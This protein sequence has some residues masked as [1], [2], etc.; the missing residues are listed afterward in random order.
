MNKTRFECE[1]SAMRYHTDATGRYQIATVEP[2]VEGNA[3]LS[4]SL[5]EPFSTTYCLGDRVVVTVETGP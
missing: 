4:A 5:R 2:V 1:I 3:L